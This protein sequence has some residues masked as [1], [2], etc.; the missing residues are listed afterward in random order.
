MGD[1][2][3][4]ISIRL[5]YLLRPAVRLEELACSTIIIIEVLNGV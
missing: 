3:R 4:F 5:V 2:I 1:S